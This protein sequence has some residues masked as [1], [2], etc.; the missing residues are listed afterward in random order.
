MADGEVQFDIDTHQIRTMPQA[1]VSKFITFVM[2]YSGGF[3]KDE[4]QANYVLI[5]F[6]VTAFI[7]SIYLFAGG[8]NTNV[9]PE[10]PSV[11]N[12]GL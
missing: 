1:R 3:I 2:K 10:I 9:A 11:S 4:T 8:T 6:V 12:L 5:I 7:I